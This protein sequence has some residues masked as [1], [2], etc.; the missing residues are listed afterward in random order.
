MTR[1]QLLYFLEWFVPGY[2]G[3][4]GACWLVDGSIGPRSFLHAIPVSL[5]IAGFSW[6]KKYL[7]VRKQMVGL[8]SETMPGVSRQ[9]T[10]LGFAGGQLVYR[11]G[12]LEEIRPVHEIEKIAVRRGRLTLLMRNGDFFAIPPKAFKSR[13]HRADFIRLLAHGA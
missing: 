7:A 9:S 6:V 3:Y 2:F 5:A 13:S 11:R 12:T 4:V 10:E 1:M 8:V